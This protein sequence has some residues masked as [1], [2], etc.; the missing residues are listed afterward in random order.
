MA[1]LLSLFIASAGAQ[2]ALQPLPYGVCPS[3]ADHATYGWSGVEIY[4]TVMHAVV[5]EDA[6]Q[7][8]ALVMEELLTQVVSYQNQN[9]KTWATACLL[10]VYARLLQQVTPPCSGFCPPEPGE[11]PQP[12]VAYAKAVEDKARRT[13]RSAAESGQVWAPRVKHL[14]AAL[15]PA[16][17]PDE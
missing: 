11:G 3:A 12:L 10:A 13:A 9:G 2:D 1:V 6:E 5:P 16:E 7:A 8:T 15:G 14:V 4:S 17:I